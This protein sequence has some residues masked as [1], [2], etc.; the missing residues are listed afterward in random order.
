MKKKISSVAHF[1]GSYLNIYLNGME[2]ALKM[3]RLE[4]EFS[5][6]V[7]KNCKRH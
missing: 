4:P 5:V 7:D 3:I 1:L 6:I 2:M